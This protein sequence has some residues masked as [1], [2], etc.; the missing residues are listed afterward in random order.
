[1]ARLLN[2]LTQRRCPTL[3]AGLH[4]DG[5][6]LYLR[7]GGAGSR[8]WIFRYRQ[9]PKLHDVGGGSYE[10]FTLAEARDWAREQRRLRRDGLDPLTEK[11]RARQQRQARCPFRVCAEEYITGIKAGWKSAASE[12]AWR[13]SLAAYAYDVIGDMPVGEIGLADVLR[14]LK[15]HWE[16]RT[17]TLDRVR[18]RIEAVLAY[19]TTHGYRTGDNPAR[20]SGHLDTIL[21]KRSKVARVEHFA[22]LPYA[23]LPGFMVRLREKGDGGY[24]AAALELAVLTCARSGEVLGASWSEINWN[25][26]TWT[27]PAV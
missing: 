15:P 8:S 23:D 11:R 4:A 26:R 27:I 5:G 13:N 25:A 19:A 12:R 14:V 3:G 7:V 22:A 6:G 16:T 20:W 9:G 17:V 21:P 10:D 18:A 1:M 24:A 2:R